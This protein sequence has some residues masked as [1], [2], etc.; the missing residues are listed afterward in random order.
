ML[1]PRARALC[2][3]ACSAAAAAYRLPAGARTL[4]GA[5]SAAG[6]ALSAAGVPEP[7]LSAEHLL[8]RAAGFGSSRAALAAAA[9]AP[10]EP[11]A[12]EAFEAMCAARL[13]RVPV[14]YILGDWDFHAL[15]LA[16]RPPVLIPRPET[17][18]LVE[19][20]LAAHAAAD[21]DSGGGGGSFLDVGCGSGAIGLALLAARPRATCVGIDVS[22][23]AAALAAENAERC[24]LGARYRAEL[25]P[26]GVA[27][28]AAPPAYDAIVSNPPYIPRADMAG[29]APEVRAHEDERA[30]C[31]GDDGLD[32]VR[33]VLEAAPRLLRPDGPRAVWLEVDPSHPPLVGAWVA[34]ARPDLGLELVRAV[35]DLQGLPRFCELRWR[36]PPRGA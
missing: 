16:L 25:V 23:A 32:V 14:Q 34:D 11:G 19:L 13:E 1:R 33:Q 29:L 20:V 4:G 30:L 15:T 27:A 26:A 22:E 10:L 6:A 7:A 17:E 12:R 36:G 5:L 28:Y 35:D 2:S 8:A 21:G 9:R 31:G 18:E 3:L 24:G